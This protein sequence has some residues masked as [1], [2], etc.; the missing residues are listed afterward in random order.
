MPRPR[1][2]I[3]LHLSHD[4]IGRRYR[5]CRSAV[6]KTHWQALWLL[7]RPEDPP[8]PPRSPHSW[9]SPPAGCGL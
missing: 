9:A 3:E 7:T 4:E 2:P 1:L 6:E 8:A 5:A